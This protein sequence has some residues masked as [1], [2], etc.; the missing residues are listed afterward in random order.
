MKDEEQLT[1]DLAFELASFAL[2]ATK[3]IGLRS[4]FPQKRFHKLS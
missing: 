1:T 3:E 2:P 4:Y